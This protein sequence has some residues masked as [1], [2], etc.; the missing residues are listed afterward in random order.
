[1]RFIKLGQYIKKSSKIGFAGN[2]KVMDMPDGGE[3][4]MML[5]GNRQVL[6]ILLHI[7]AHT[8]TIPHTYIII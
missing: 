2:T 1:M 5:I 3:L 6:P 4:V 8:H 7:Y